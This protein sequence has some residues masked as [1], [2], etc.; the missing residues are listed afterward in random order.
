MTNRTFRISIVAALCVFAAGAN[1]T[2]A[3]TIIVQDSLGNNPRMFTNLDSAVIHANPHDYLYISRGTYNITSN[4][5]GYAG[6][7]SNPNYLV[8]EKPLHFVGNGYTTPPLNTVIT[9]TF[10]LRKAASGSTITG[11]KFNNAVYLDSV[12]N[13]LIMRCQ[14]AGTTAANS[15]YLCGTGANNMISECRIDGGILGRTN[16]TAATSATQTTWSSYTSFTIIKN[17]FTGAIGGANAAA[18]LQYHHNLLVT[19]NIFTQNSATYYYE[20]YYL[21]NLTAQN[22]IFTTTSNGH[23]STITNSL[24]QNNITPLSAITVSSGS[25]NTIQ[26][27]KTA[28]SAANTFVNIAGGDY[29]LKPTSVGV[30]AGTDGTDIGIYG[31]ATPFKANMTTAYP[32]IPAA[33][34]A[35][36][37][38]QGK[39]KVNISVEAQDR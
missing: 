16:I 28:A 17:I 19:N 13:V 4:W 30:N 27:N 33:N 7:A 2:K 21:N 24:I 10:I 23:F 31:T 12:S 37:T 20:F 25:N 35:P 11:I 36:E 5:A 14:S 6:T 34:V 1:P 9:G 18:N 15:I 38:H 22:N 3:Q 8:V 32:Q 39:L 26:N 29:H